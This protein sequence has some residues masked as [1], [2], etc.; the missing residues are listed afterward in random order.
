M[1]ATFRMETT[2]V[3]AGLVFFAISYAP[4]ATLGHVCRMALARKNEKAADAFVLKTNADGLALIDV[5]KKLAVNHLTNLNPHPLFV[6]LYHSHPPI[7]E[8][9]EAIRAA[10]VKIV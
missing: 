1:Y 6:W 4:L 8:R 9:I 3:Y 2:P 5:L 10:A 7:A